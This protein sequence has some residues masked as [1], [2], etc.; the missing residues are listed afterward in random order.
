MEI[1]KQGR[2]LHVTIKNIPILIL[3]IFFYIISK[4]LVKTYGSFGSSNNNF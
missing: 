1:S 3:N 2:Y 4:L